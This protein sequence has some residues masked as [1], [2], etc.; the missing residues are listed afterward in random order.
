MGA[1]HHRRESS[2]ARGYKR[3]VVG[4]WRYGDI[5]MKTPQLQDG[6]KVSCWKSTLHRKHRSRPGHA[7]VT[8][9]TITPHVVAS[10]RISQLVSHFERLGKNHLV[11]VQELQS[12]FKSYRATTLPQSLSACGESRAILSN[13]R[14]L[15]ETKK[16]P[17]G[18]PYLCSES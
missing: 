12:R 9:G 14:M 7:T 15:Y 2:H 18:N 4:G 11:G 6:Y 5:G 10:L 16:S 3:N 1:A 8:A 17:N 13:A